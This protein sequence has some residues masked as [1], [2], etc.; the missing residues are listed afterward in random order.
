[1]HLAHLVHARLRGRIFRALVSVP[2]QVFC[3]AGFLAGLWLLALLPVRVLL[4]AAGW[5]DALA[6]LRPLDA[7]P[8]ALALASLAT[9][10]RR[11]PSGADRPLAEPD[12]RNRRVRGAPPASAAAPGPSLRLVQGRTRTGP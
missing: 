2:A 3:A 7:L 10:L 1:V 9:S 5:D 6:W 11:R 8:L 4:A 12:R